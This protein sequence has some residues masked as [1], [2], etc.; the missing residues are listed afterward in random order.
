MRRICELNRARGGGTFSIFV[1]MARSSLPFGRICGLTAVSNVIF[2][3]NSLFA[4]TY[5]LSRPNEV[6]D[7]FTPRAKQTTHLRTKSRE[8]PDAKDKT[9]KQAREYQTRYYL[10]P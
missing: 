5:I 7:N 9:T 10:N 6:T 8:A 2:I 4:L 1:K 3:A